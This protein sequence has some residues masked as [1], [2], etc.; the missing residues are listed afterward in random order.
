MG[1]LWSADN[2]GKVIVVGRVLPLS[3]PARV[4]VVVASF[5]QPSAEYHVHSNAS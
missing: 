5:M 4:K 3:G 1:S 2:R